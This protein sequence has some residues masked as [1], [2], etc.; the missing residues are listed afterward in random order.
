MR[1][2]LSP[3]AILSRFSKDI[4]PPNFLNRKVRPFFTNQQIPILIN[5]ENAESEKESEYEEEEEE[6]ERNENENEEEEQYEEEINETEA[7][8]R[9]P[10]NFHILQ[11]PSHGIK[12]NMPANQKVYKLCDFQ[13]LQLDI[14]ELATHKFLSDFFYYSFH[15]ISLIKQFYDNRA[16]FSLSVSEQESPALNYLSHFSRNKLINDINI[17]TGPNNIMR[18]QKN[19]LFRNGFKAVPTKCSY[20]ILSNDL[21]SYVFYG[22][23]EAHYQKDHMEVLA[24]CRTFLISNRNGFKITNDHIFVSLIP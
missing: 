12:P 5:I 14:N 15:E 2:V 21:I 19:K 3:E 13:S 1:K 24:F 20:K 4:E 22:A 11:K 8:F 7:L 17:V 23:F 18:L 16:D 10:S 6:E 9:P